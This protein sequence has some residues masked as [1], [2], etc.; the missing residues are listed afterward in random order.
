MRSSRVNIGGGGGSLDATFS[1]HRAAA[2]AAAWPG[3]FPRGCCSLRCD[4]VGRV[5][6]EADRSR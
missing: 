5:I 3:V 2:A 6:G 4:G 1:R